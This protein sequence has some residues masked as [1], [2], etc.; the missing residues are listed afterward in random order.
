MQAAGV[1]LKW[2]ETVSSTFQDLESDGSFITT[3]HWLMSKAWHQK[4]V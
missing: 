3:L 4:T 2:L 1:S